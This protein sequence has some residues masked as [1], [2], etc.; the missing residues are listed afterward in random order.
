MNLPSQQKKTVFKEVLPKTG[1]IYSQET[2]QLVSFDELESLIG[3][4]EI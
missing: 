2:P 1:M 3:V 4:R